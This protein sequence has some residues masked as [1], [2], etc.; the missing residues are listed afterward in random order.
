MASPAPEIK[1]LLASGQVWFSASKSFETP[2][3]ET[4]AIWGLA[5]VAGRFVELGGT[6]AS[7]ALT[8]ATSLVLDAQCL[9]EPAVWVTRPEAFFFP[10]DVAECGVDLGG[11]AVVRVPSAAAMLRVADCCLRSGA[12]GLVVLDLGEDAEIP[13][14]VQVRLSGLAKRHDAALVCLS[15]RVSARGSLASLRAVSARKRVGEGRFACSLR[16]VKDK[17]RGWEWECAQVF[18]GPV[19]LR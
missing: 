19:G 1:H 2:A 12:F 13:L 6:G 10:L 5:E 18:R 17:R 3:A 14:P 7:A 15:E 4:P 8:A 9:E 11:L 16:M